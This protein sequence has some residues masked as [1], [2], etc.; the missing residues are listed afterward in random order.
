MGYFS[1]FC[2]KLPKVNNHTLGE[3]S[4]NLATLLALKVSL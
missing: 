3:N 2:N 4:P 1:N